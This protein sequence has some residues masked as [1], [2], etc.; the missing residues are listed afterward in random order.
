MAIVAFDSKPIRRKRPES[1]QDFQALLGIGVRIED[2]GKFIDA[3]E[4]I[5]RTELKG[6]EF[7]AKK[8]VYCS[9]ELAQISALKGID[10][11]PLIA[12]RYGYTGTIG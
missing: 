5:I 9:S 2:Y 10:L 7:T 1:Q 3:Y 4:H 8:S 12:E 11:I 6:V